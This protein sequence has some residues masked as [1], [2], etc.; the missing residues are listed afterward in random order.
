MLGC[1]S[2]KKHCSLRRRCLVTI[3]LVLGDRFQAVFGLLAETPV[4]P[5]QDLLRSQKR[6]FSV[7][8]ERKF[9]Q[10]YLTLLANR[11]TF[12]DLPV[13]L[14]DRPLLFLGPATHGTHRLREE[15]VV[16]STNG[17]PISRGKP[18]Q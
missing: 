10:G 18:V 2:T 11:P 4:H 14:L 13:A 17:W 6:G 3:L 8:P 12:P 7:S 16:A 15:G 1:P 9:V 5:I